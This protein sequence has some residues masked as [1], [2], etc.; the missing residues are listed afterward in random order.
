MNDGPGGDGACRRPCPAG[1]ASPRRFSASEARQLARLFAAAFLDAQ[2][3]DTAAGSPG[4]K[5]PERCPSRDSPPRNRADSS[6]ETHARCC[7][8]R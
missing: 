1:A 7:A 4:L 8:N 5:V 2:T 6:A 3:E